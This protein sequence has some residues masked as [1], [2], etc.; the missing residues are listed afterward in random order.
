MMIDVEKLR[1]R[2]C[3]MGFETEENEDAAL[4]DAIERAEQTVMNYCNCESVP[5]ELYFVALDMAAGEFLLA[6][7]CKGAENAEIKSISEG[8]VSV[9]FKDDS[10][11]EQIDA[12][13]SRGREEM[14]SFRRLKW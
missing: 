6:A 1:E 14:I 12:L 3:D 7:E 5:E 9:S 13:F 2:L 11:G 4:K 10:V 8:D